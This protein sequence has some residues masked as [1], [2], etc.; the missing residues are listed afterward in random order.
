MRVLL[1]IRSDVARFP[2]GDHVQLL[3][4]REALG[5][6]GVEADVLPGIAAP[7]RGYDVVHLFNTTRIHET[8]VQFR[9]ARAQGTPVV[10]STIWHS[11]AEMQRFYGHLYGWP[12][13]PLGI[14]QALKEAW[15]ARR[16]GL[17][18]F[19]PAV[20]RRA[21]LQREIAAGADAVLPNSRAELEILRREL[22]VEPRA[23]FVIPNGFDAAHCPAPGWGM[24]RDVLCVGRIEP[25][26]NQLGVIRAFKRLPRGAHRLLLFGAMNAAHDSYTERVRAELVP[27]WIEYAGCVSQKEIYRALAGAAVV[28]LASFFETCG[29]VAMEALACGAQACVSRSPYLED[30]YGARV[31]YCDPYDLASIATGL[32]AALARPSQDHREFLRGYSWQRAGE[33]TLRAYEHVLAARNAAGIGREATALPSPLTV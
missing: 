24:R 31:E 22:R 16:S 3:K 8:A 15:Y 11:D 10:V 20:L 5:A 19:W 14:Y 26:K 29:L 1:R 2:G 32:A 4:T 28:V 12:F 18:L 6:L 21:S 30:Y 17:P 9:Q 27:G 13:F 7:P 33:A 25:R 23:A